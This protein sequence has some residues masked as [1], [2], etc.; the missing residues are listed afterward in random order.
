MENND[1]DLYIWDKV[2]LINCSK[3]KIYVIYSF[4][5]YWDWRIT[6]TIWVDDEYEVVEPWQVKPYVAPVNI[7]FNKDLWQDQSQ[8]LSPSSN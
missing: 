7:W 6:Y 1:N 4:T 5:T 2:Q 3:G 8:E